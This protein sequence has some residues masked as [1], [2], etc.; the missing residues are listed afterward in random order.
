MS[1]LLVNGYYT[2]RSWRKQ[3]EI[4]HLAFDDEQ[5]AVVCH[6]QWRPVQALSPVLVVSWLTILKLKVDGKMYVLSL[7][8]DSAEADPLR[9]LRVWLLCGRWKR[10]GQ[11][12]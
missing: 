8:R 4:T 10:R 6:G 1:L 2:H 9:Q 11:A 3:G 7:W 5:L 12:S